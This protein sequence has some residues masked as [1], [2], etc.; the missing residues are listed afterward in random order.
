MSEHE[1]SETELKF[2]GSPSPAL[3]GLR[4]MSPKF[5]RS[6]P[7]RVVSS[8]SQSGGNITTPN[9]DTSSRSNGSDVRERRRKRISSQAASRSVNRERARTGRK[10]LNNSFRKAGSNHTSSDEEHEILCEDI[11]EG[12]S[13]E[14]QA[15]SA[16]YKITTARKR[17][18]SKA[19]AIQLGFGAGA[20]G[21][22]SKDGSSSSSKS[23]SYTQE[24]N[25]GAGSGSGAGSSGSM[26]SSS[27]PAAD[28]G[29]IRHNP[30]RKGPRNT[31]HCCNKGRIL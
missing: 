31:Y 16:I 27:R 13:S 8:G 2:V 20:F 26:S 14:Q 9:S 28:N 18:K 21:S 15:E 17:R 10:A 11:R 4:P 24:S 30:K 19:R 3:K 6:S 1:E 12:A 25:S 22:T 5:G 7:S 29:T 23:E